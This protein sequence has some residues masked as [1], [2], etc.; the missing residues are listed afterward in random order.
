M[1]KLPQAPSLLLSMLVFFCA[2]TPAIAQF[3]PNKPLKPELTPTPLNANATPRAGG[4]SPG[5]PGCPH[6]FRCANGLPGCPDQSPD[7]IRGIVRSMDWTWSQPDAIPYVLSPRRTLLLTPQPLL[8][9]HPVAEADHYQVTVLDEVTG[10]VVWET[11]EPIAA[12]EVTYPGPALEAGREYYLEVRAY[13]A[14]S[15]IAIATSQDDPHAATFAVLE[16][17]QQQELQSAAQAIT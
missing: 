7:D 2:S 10:A 16:T 12:T 6:T 14:G 3:N 9:W 8:R 17:S 15:D 5:I 13:R 1:V 11:S 4:C